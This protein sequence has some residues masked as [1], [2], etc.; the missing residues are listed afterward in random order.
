[1]PIEPY[2]VKELKLRSISEVFQDLPQ[3]Y[4]LKEYLPMAENALLILRLID[5]F[6]MYEELSKYS[7]TGAEYAQ[8]LI[9]T[10][11]EETMETEKAIKNKTI[12]RDRR[13]QTVIY[14]GI[15][16]VI[17][18]LTSYSGI[19]AKMIYGPSSDISFCAV[20]DITGELK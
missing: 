14:W 6:K 12:P 13:R 7:M 15:P 10:R 9:K 11:W 4:R 16:P 3:G 2:D 17:P 5:S 8:I 18:M 20:N 19:S 1:M